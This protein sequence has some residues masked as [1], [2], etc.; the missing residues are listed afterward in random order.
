[1]DPLQSNEAIQQ[2]IKLL[3]ENNRREQSADLSQLMWYMDGMTRQFEAVSRELQE[4]KQQLAQVTQPSIKY[5]MQGAAAR[6]KHKVECAKK[7]LDSLWK[8]IAGCA[9]AAVENFKE[10]GVAAL[11]KA[12]SKLGVK[13]TL[14][15]LQENLSGVI[16]DTKQNI[17]KVENIGHEL[18]SMG[19]HLKN[20]GRAMRGREVQRIDGGK[21]GRFQSAVLAPMRTTQKLLSHMNNA[22]LAT[23]GKI[24]HLEQTAKTVREARAEREAEKKP[25]IRE[26]LAKEKAEAAA[27][28]APTPEQD[29][30][31][32][33][34]AL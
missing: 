1:M 7:T 6:L 33:E 31:M 13:H 4:V 18:R 30:K 17:E 24:E 12:V 25:S 11:D 20:A 22:T 27:R 3:E 10:T 28:P 5:A 16:V 19:G 14:E 26:A 29:R 21:E 8:K 9:A 2:F 32:M 34:A 15:S 23:I